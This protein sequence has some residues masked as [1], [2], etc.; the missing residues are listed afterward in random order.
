MH[1]QPERKQEDRREEPSP[2]SLTP[3]H[4]KPYRTPRLVAYGHLRDI[5]MAKGGAK[6]D[7]GGVPSTK[8]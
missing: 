3:P 2:E 4:K 8:A 5:T 6:G 1:D 7:G